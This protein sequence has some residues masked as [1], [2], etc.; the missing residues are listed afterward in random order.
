[1]MLAWAPLPPETFTHDAF[2]GNSGATI[3]STGTRISDHPG[4]E[5]WA[6]RTKDGKDAGSV[7][8]YVRV[9]ADRESHS[10][11]DR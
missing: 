11:H 5:T 6:S 7:A 10:I 3:V 2:V 8:Y 1:M 9:L 4:S